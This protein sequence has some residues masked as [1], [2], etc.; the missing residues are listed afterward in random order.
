[1]PCCGVNSGGGVIGGADGSAGG[2][3][4]GVAGTSG[5]GVK[6]GADVAVCAKAPALNSTAMKKLERD[7]TPLVSSAL[8]FVHFTAMQSIS[9]RAPLGKAETCTVARAG[10][11]TGKYR[12]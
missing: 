10:G 1:M 3:G 8:N 11:L 6:S 7:I 12:A 4:G 2:S 9:T 5:G